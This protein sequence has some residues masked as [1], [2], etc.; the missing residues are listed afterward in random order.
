M[1]PQLAASL[2]NESQLEGNHP[3]GRLGP[4]C[5][6]FWKGSLRDRCRRLEFCSSRALVGGRHHF[7]TT[8]DLQP[9]QLLVCPVSPIPKSVVYSRTSGGN[10]I[11]NPAIGV[12]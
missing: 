9:L 3:P 12:P 10:R 8:R 11:R 7:P 4:D 1:L 5:D 2:G 6:H